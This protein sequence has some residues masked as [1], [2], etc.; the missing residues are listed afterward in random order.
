MCS[1]PSKSLKSSSNKGFG[2]IAGIAVISFFTYTGSAHGLQITPSS[3]TASNGTS[4]GY[5]LNALIDNSGLSNGLHGAVTNTM[6]LSQNQTTPTLT[7][8]LGAVYN[9]AGTDIWQ[10]NRSTF[11][12]G[13]QNFNILTSLDGINFSSAGS[14]TL[15]VATGN[16]VSIPSQLVAFTATAQYVRFEVTSNYGNTFTTGLSEVKFQTA[17]SVPEPL[18]ILGSLT[19]LGFGSVFKKKFKSSKS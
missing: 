11:N 8:N 9:L 7:F 13:V 12:R 4:N 16:P 1:P 14:G 19:A 3:V 6:W 10:Y 5:S 17:E 18:T 15:T 2:K